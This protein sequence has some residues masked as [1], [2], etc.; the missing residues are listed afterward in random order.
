M[1]SDPYFECERIAM[2]DDG[3]GTHKKGTLVLSG[4]LKPAEAR[5]LPGGCHMEDRHLQDPMWVG[6]VHDPGSGRELGKIAYDEKPEGAEVMAISCLLCS[7]GKWY[8]LS[9]EWH[10]SCLALVP[11]SKSKET[12]RRV[13]LVFLGQY[14]WFG[15]LSRGNEYMT[16]IPRLGTIDRTRIRLV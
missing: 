10:V 6:S 1:R 4:C 16:S 5:W 12:Y 8:A 14:D 15:I 7:M 13:G 2:D 11:T 3:E 9:D